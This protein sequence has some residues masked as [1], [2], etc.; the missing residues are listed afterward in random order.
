MGRIRAGFRFNIGK[1]GRVY[2]PV[3]GGGSGGGGGKKGGGLWKIVKWPLL[4]I[5][6][7]AIFS[8]S[9]KN[10]EPET[11]PEPSAAVNAIE[12]LQEEPVTRSMPEPTEEAVLAPSG[13]RVSTSEPE[14]SPEPAEL[15]EV[16]PEPTPDATPAPTEEPTPEPTKDPA[17]RTYVLNTNTKKFHVPGCSSIKDIKDKNKREVECTREELIAQGYDP[18]GR[19]HP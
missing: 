2:V 19:C 9:K 15:T 16:T 4:L 13:R 14:S 17:I 10:K 18:C 8:P 1:H 12:G 3:T 7:F 6:I 5:L 11:T